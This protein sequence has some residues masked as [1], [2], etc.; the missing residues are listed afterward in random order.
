M[1]TRI[2]DAQIVANG[3]VQRASLLIGNDGRIDSLIPDDEPKPQADSV[4]DASSNILLPGGI[5]EHVHFRDPGL[6]H[7]ADMA[8]ESAAALLGGVTSVM[9]MPNVVP[10]T[11]T[12]DAW[13]DKMDDA[14]RKMLTNYAFYL[15]ATND[16]LD[17]LLKADYSKVAAIKFFMGSST[18]GM[19]LDDHDT[20]GKLFA[21]SPA[22]LVGHCERQSVIKDNEAKA[23]AQFADKVPWSAHRDIRPTKACIEATDEAISLAQKNRAKIHILHIST[24]EEV[25]SIARADRSLVSAE[26]CPAYLWFND[27]DYNNYGP[28]IKCNPSIKSPDDMMALRNALQHGIIDTVGSDHAPH[29]M[30]EK[31]CHPYW[32]TPSGMPMV[33]HSLPVLL[34]LATQGAITLPTVARAMSERVAEVYGIKDRGHITPGAWADLVLVKQQ[35]NVVTNVP[36]KCQW[37]PLNGAKLSHVVDKVFL[38]G[39]LAVQDGNITAS[40]AMPLSFS[41]RQ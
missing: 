5:D 25:D 7:K 6:T 36:Y 34:T 2:D 26:T 11:V 16:N 13:Q 30:Q 24:K 33:A 29:T 10:Q 20:L 41:P 38:N 35:E 39:K 40:A 31:L 21:Q 37:S 28:L 23:R 4:I 14:K 27:S 32:Q 18:G 17:T 8:S 19:L 22:L 15:G 1:T 12:I 9:D 3:K